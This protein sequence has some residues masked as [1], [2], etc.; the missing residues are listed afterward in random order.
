M[1]PTHPA[2]SCAV[3]LCS[4]VALCNAN[5]NAPVLPK[6]EPPP[7]EPKKDADI[8]DLLKNMK[9]MPGMEN[10][11]M[12]TAECVSQLLTHL[13]PPLHHHTTTTTT[14]CLGL[15]CSLP[16]SLLTR[17]TNAAT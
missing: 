9:G 13:P 11:K 12:F 1:P 14:L 15:F 3:S 17:A 4:F 16:N 5:L 7:A 6:E 8:D 2:C 10:I